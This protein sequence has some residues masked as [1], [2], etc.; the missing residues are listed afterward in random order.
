[1][2]AGVRQISENVLARAEGRTV[3]SEKPGAKLLDL[4]PI[5]RIA[6]AA[7]DIERAGQVRG[8]IGERRVFIV[9][10]GQRIRENAVRRRQA[11][12]VKKDKVLL[13]VVALVGVKTTN[14]PLK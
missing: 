6:H 5:V 13:I 7:C 12:E 1:M 8:Q 11:C 9:A 3:G 2:V 10:R 14:Q 4:L